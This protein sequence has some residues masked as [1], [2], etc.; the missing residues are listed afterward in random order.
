MAFSLISP[1]VPPGLGGGLPG[2]AAR[3]A[4]GPVFRAIKKRRQ[5]SRRAR[6]RI[7]S[8]PL[9]GELSFEVMDLPFEPL[10]GFLW[11]EDSLG[12]VFPEGSEEAQPMAG[13]GPMA[14]PNVLG[15]AQVA[16]DFLGQRLRRDL[17]DKG[18]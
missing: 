18:L 16:P 14:L 5:A 1:S 4:G 12:Q 17:A 15:G 8:G 11:V 13:D 9:F 10:D 2:W 6:S 7:R 3:Y